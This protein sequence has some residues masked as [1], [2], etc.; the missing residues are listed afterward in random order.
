MGDFSE[1]DMNSS[2][3]SGALPWA[4]HPAIYEHISS[5]TG[6]DGK[7]TEEGQLLPDDERKF[8]E[9]QIRWAAGAMDGTLSHH[10]FGDGEADEEEPE[11]VSVIVDLIGDIASE[12][13]LDSRIRLY[14]LLCEDNLLFYIDPVIE[15]IVDSKVPIAPHLHA[16]LR[17]MAFECP[18]RGP[19]KFAMALLGLIADGRDLPGIIA[20]GR[21]DEFTLYSAV[22]I[23][24][25]LE[26]PDD[27][28]WELGRS[29]KGWGRIQIVER[30]AE[31]ENPEIKRWFLRE[32]F[33]NNVMN[34]YLAHLC[35]IKGGLLAELEADQV[36]DELLDGATGLLE[37]FIY[38]GPGPHISDYEDGV[39]V[40]ALFVEQ[41]QDR[42][43]TLSHFHVLYMIR[44]FLE[45]ED[46][47]WSEMRGLG[48]TEDTRTNLLIEIHGIVARPHWKELVSEKR[49]TAT[50]EEFWRVRDTA[51]HL[52]IEMWRTYRRRLLERPEDP[53]CWYDIMRCVD[54]EHIDEVIDLARAIV[55]LGEIATGV[56]EEIGFG[57]AFV[58]HQNLESVLE[59]LGEFPGKGTDLV[60]AALQS[61][62]IR[63]RHLALRVLDGWG[64]V[65]WPAGM[66]KK[67][68]ES[69]PQEPDSEI[70]EMM[71]KVLIGEDL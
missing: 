35:A 20:L 11:E 31:T 64:E 45:D 66:R 13:S 46:T 43:K 29:V 15:K 65:N 54:A 2:N 62:M 18:D 44:E 40:V 50:E 37:A 38:S 69:L 9:E 67:L 1:T 33:R 63:S 26:E 55:P 53:G 49:D 5:H 47:D 16:F 7:L 60:E 10:S 58:A 21:H 30:L 52:G 68:T 48:W 24:N 8:G 28:L 41:M 57:T 23:S 34:E 27:V 39:E 6:E 12:N 56:G 32:G 51:E 22:A 71:E 61:P 25:M 36:D 42:A 4:E 59:E 14:E 3:P 19:V 70:K 17:F